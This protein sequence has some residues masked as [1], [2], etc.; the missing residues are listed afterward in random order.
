MVA[1]KQLRK[2]LTKSKSKTKTK[3]QKKKNKEVPFYPPHETNFHLKDQIEKDD[4][5]LALED[6]IFGGDDFEKVDK[7]LTTFGEEDIIQ[8]QNDLNVPI[9]L[10]DQDETPLFVIDKEG[11]NDLKSNVELKNDLEESKKRSAWTDDDQ[12]DMNISEVKR[13]RK[14][15][16]T[17]DE[18]FLNNEE[19]E[20]RLRIQF[21]KTYGKQSWAKI[22]E[23]D[24]D[25]P[26]FSTTKR[27]INQKNSLIKP[28][29]IEVSRMADA[30]IQ[31]YN[32]SIVSSINWH[33]KF[34]IMV[35][36]GKDK[37]LRI[38]QIDGK[39]NQK[40]QSFTFK[41]MSSLNSLFSIDGSEVIVT[42]D[43]KYFYSYDM[44]SG[45]VNKIHRIQG[46]DEKS[47]SRFVISPCN[48]YIAFIGIKGY[49]ILVSRI[50]K[51]WI[52]NLKMNGSVNTLCFSSNGQYIYSLGN[53]GE[54]YKWNLEDK[55]CI[56]KIFDEGSIKPTTITCSP[57]GN[58]L[59]TGSSSGVVNVYNLEN[60]FETSR[61]KP[62]KAF[63]NITTAIHQI[64][65]NHDSQL[66][67]ICSHAKKDQFRLI[68]LPSL[69]V[70]QNWPTQ[71]TPL[72]YVSCFGFSHNSE[73]LSI[74][75]D[76][77]KVLLYQ[78]KHYI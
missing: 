31:G 73:Y 40:L 22:N 21:E 4:E 14:L 38:F 3:T 11:S 69:T 28:E 57:D 19:Y 66:L 42:S 6:A 1:K 9:T 16:Q 5:E 47:L 64:T 56:G 25:E 67:G 36:C 46:R 70:Y 58:W 7:I 71:K 61:P 51:Q 23:N 13:L 20:N 41:D 35:T 32:H 8:N 18:T 54:I 48:K 34:P 30:N 75:N 45:T 2:P 60:L 63:F 17:P 12:F 10:E 43:R 29:L 27:I 37:T 44:E 77:G 62:I 15:R 55:T 26:I 76:K 74:G 39:V 65:F 24:Q 50:T 53:D 52:A 68:H 72:G 59:A 49:I 33:P 78:L